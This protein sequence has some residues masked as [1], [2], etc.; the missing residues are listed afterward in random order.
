MATAMDSTI[1]MFLML[2]STLQNHPKERK[3][4][5]EG[6]EGQSEGKGH[7]NNAS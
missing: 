1:L 2:G 7:G 6:S 5:L 4:S 3:S